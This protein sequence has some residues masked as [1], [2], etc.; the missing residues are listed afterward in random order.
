MATHVP[1]D[2]HGHTRFSDGRA[3]P[4]DYVGFRA[5]LG[6][7]VIAVSDHDTFAAVP[8]AAEAARAL[9]VTLVPAMEVTSFIHFGTARAEQIHVLA[10]FPPERAFDGSLAHTRL[11]ARAVE[12][13]HRW[14]EL[15]LGW[16]TALPE[17]QRWFVDPDRRLASLR[18]TEFPAL[19]DF[20]N[21]LLARNRLVYQ[22]FVRYHVAFWEED[23]DL[24]GWTPEEAIE[25]IRADGALDVVAHPVRV[26]DK[27]RMDRVLAA[28]A[29]IEVYTSRHKHTVAAEFRARAEATGKHWTASADDHGHVAYL[30]PPEGTP[31]RT[32]ERIFAGA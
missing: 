6:L 7:E 10:Y 30:P 1:T 24:F 17:D 5:G 31:R 26:R 32:I 3:E 22:D 19:Q 29:G 21:L 12:V 8:R 2:L 9:D 20:L 14:R 23:D 15:C 16:L 18:G 25:E 4:E 11:G 28:A 13:C 27:A